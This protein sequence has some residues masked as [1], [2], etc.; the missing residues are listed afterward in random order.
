MRG[1]VWLAALLLTGCATAGTS[2]P[3]GGGLAA[4]TAI[5]AAAQR[6]V[7]DTVVDGDTLWVRADGP[8]ALA[9]GT[10][11]KVRLL[12]ID[13]PERGECGFEAASGALARLTPPGSTVWLVADR[14][15]VDRYGRA[16]RYV[17][18]AAGVFVDLEM[19]RTGMGRA[20]LVQPNDAH[21]GAIRA[22]QRQAERARR[23]LWESC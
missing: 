18:T 7:V 6:A 19:V 8:G 17:W 12:E 2:T 16:L 21:I 11:T 13:T 9:R 3:E 15:P 20:L 1:A 23:G 22:A 10:R 4:P 14:E 5:P